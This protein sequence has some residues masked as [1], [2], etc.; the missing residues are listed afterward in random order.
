MNDYL[1]KY[2]KGYQI[3]Y[4]LLSASR[5]S[6]SI[7]NGC[8]DDWVYRAKGDDVHI[9]PN[10]ITYDEKGV[11]GCLDMYT[12]SLFLSLVRSGQVNESLDR[13]LELKNLIE[14]SNP[15]IFYYPASPLSLR[16]KRISPVFIYDNR[17]KIT[18]ISLS[19]SYYSI[20]LYPS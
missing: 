13:I 5:D 8:V 14:N 11:Y 6:C 4:G 20:Y 19:L 10:L 18:L 2:Q 3:Y 12:I 9:I 1:F 17:T 15:L 7:F 16:I